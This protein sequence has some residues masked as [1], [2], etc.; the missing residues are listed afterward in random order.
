MQITTKPSYAHVLKQINGAIRVLEMYP[1]GHPA[2]LQATEK[3]FSALQ[4][5][6]KET[7]HFTISRVE[8]R[9]VVNGKNIE[10]SD[11]LKRLM[12]E[13]NN[14]NTSSLTL[15]KDLTKEE[16]GKFLSFFVKPLNKDALPKSLPEFLKRNRIQSIKVDQLKYE[17]VTEDEVV[18]K[19]EVVEGADLKAHISK[20]MKDNP[21]LMRDIVLDKSVRQE[22]L[23]EEFGAEIELKQLTEE[24]GKQIKNLSDDQ[25]L[26]LLASNL[27]QN[28]KESESKNSGSALNEVVDL[29]DKLLGDR[30]KRKLL[31]QIKKVLSERGI[32]E[33]EHLDFL[34]EE[35]WLKSQEVLDELMGMIEKLGRQ[36]V[37][38]EKFMF[39]WHRV[40]SSEDTKIKSYAMEEL[41][42][43]LNSENAQTRN[44]VIS[45]VEKALNH[46]INE[47]LEFEFLYI[48]DRLYEKI[49]DQLL[50]AHILKDCSRLLKIT[51]LEMFQQQEFKEI[52]K[53][54]LEYNT[55]SCSETTHPQEVKKIAQDFIK[56]ISDESKLAILVSQVKE[57]VPFVTIKLIEEILESLDKD[58]VAEKLTDIFTLDDRAARISALRVLSRLG[59]SSVSVL[60]ALLSN[61]GTFIRKKGTALLVDEQWYK[62][63]N[64]IY[65]LGNIP[66]EERVPA[67][68]K[69]SQDPDIR[70]RLEVVKTLEKIGRP[71]SV[72]VLLTFLNDTEDEVRR[73]AITSLTVLD[74]KSCL[75]PLMEHLRYN[76]RDRKITLTAIGKIG[77]EDS[78]DFLLELL[79][80]REKG[81]QHLAPRQKDEIKIAV[82]N[83]LGKT[84][85]SELTEEVEKFVKQR[86]KGL[87][88]LLV[89]DKVLESANGALKTIESRNKDYS[90]SGRK[91]MN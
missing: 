65:V 40:I 10:G 82:L 54:L 52:H 18:V 70:V 58:K 48:K 62:V 63:R 25:I 79:W 88:N 72:N 81:I 85:S 34:F 60:V 89:K 30:E 50:P 56:E 20:I 12:E 49:K 24:V 15:T 21:E 19:A 3:P 64:A 67:L 17:L 84:G 35:K 57:G 44:F 83:I 77:K 26:S 22:E 76:H 37:D 32:V 41:L 33:R 71:E 45:A 75:K 1:S 9:I 2:T 73:N 47:K 80:E 91:K 38:F 7:N 6:F 31:P 69:L 29:V 4:E 74:D 14:Q 55:R 36:E 90:G 28:L 43:K 53:I 39:L 86:E 68:S 87:M 78:I 66:S 16:F 11:I 5:I 51:L 27:E 23:G 13:F 42:A 59:K 61:P 8:E 46:F